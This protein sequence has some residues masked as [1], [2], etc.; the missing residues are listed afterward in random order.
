MGRGDQTMSRQPE[1]GAKGENGY[2]I[3]RRRDLRRGDTMT[4]SRALAILL[5]ATAVALLPAM[6]A[7]QDKQEN[8]DWP[9]I[10]PLVPRISPAQVWSGSV[11]DP[12]KLA[13]AHDVDSLALKIA[14]R[15]LP[16]EEADKLIEEFAKKQPQGMADEKLTLLFGR[17]LQI[18]NSDRASIIAGLERFTK[19]QRA[20]SERIRKNQA[21]LQDEHPTGEEGQSLAEALKWDT[22]LFTERQH[23]LTYL[24][25]QPVVLEHRAFALGQAIGNRL[26]K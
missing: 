20:L 9:C 13:K 3:S 15:R 22:R 5:A 18:I 17:T 14:A 25:E 26:E 7:A 24:C 19:G 6:A 2:D 23:T 11:P 21:K 10:Q 8:S 12:A 1:G 16:I 4:I